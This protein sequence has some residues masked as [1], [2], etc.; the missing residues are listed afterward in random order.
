MNLFPCYL[1]YLVAFLIVKLSR[2][3][4]LGLGIAFCVLYTR[5]LKI[6]FLSPRNVLRVK[7]GQD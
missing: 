4:F 7:G 2:R 5:S 1:P 6:N 3:N